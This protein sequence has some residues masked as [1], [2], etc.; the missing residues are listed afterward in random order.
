MLSPFGRVRI[1]TSTQAHQAKFKI[2]AL[3]KIVR[4]TRRSEVQAS[5]RNASRDTVSMDFDFF[6][7]P[8]N[9]LAPLIPLANN[10]LIE[11]CSDWQMLLWL[12]I[13]H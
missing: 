11:C 9:D 12:S 5:C 1:D 7:V 3:Q 2:M 6:E 10:L 4:S 13:C 8:I